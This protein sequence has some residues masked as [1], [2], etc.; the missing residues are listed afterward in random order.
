M[1]ESTNEKLKEARK[2]LPNRTGEFLLNW[3]VSTE[4]IR[5]FSVS[6]TCMNCVCHCLTDERLFTTI[7]C[8]WI[9][10]KAKHFFPRRGA[11]VC[12]C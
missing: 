9:F 3:T 4:F 6:V 2:I 10:D 7:M 8:L 1:R 11:P 12:L 5:T